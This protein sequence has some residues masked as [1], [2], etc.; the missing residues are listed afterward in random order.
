MPTL[1]IANKPKPQIP[2]IPREIIRNFYTDIPKLPQT[3]QHL[4]TETHDWSVRQAKNKKLNN[5]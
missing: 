4:H 5:K 1:K 3:N 2:E